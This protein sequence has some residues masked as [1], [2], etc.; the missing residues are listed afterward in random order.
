MNDEDYQRKQ[1]RINK[2]RSLLSNPEEIHIL[3][4]RVRYS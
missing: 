2:V 3:Q 1:N 4:V